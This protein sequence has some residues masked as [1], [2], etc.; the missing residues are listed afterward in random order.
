[1]IP[2]VPTSFSTAS[3]PRS[4]N[5][6]RFPFRQG[7]LQGVWVSSIAALLLGGL[8]LSCG[9]EKRSAG[10]AETRVILLITVDTLRA[11]RLGFLGY[12]RETSP[13]LDAWAR[14][15]VVFERTVAQFPKTGPSLAALFTSRYPQTTGLTH[16]AA[17]RLP[18][19]LP[20][21]PELLRS[22]GF[23]AGAVVS[24]P[25]LPRRL[26]WA[27]GFDD[28]QEVW[29]SDAEAL[30]DPYR[31]RRVTEAQRVNEAA[32]PL[33]R[34]AAERVRGG[35][36]EFLW[37][38]YSDPHAPYQLPPGETN[39]FLGDRWFVGEETALPESWAA[40]DLD[41]R[42]DLRY[43]VAQYDANV[44]YVDRRIGELLDEAKRVGLLAEGLVV[45]T[46]DHGESLGEHGA[47]FDHGG[48]PYATTSRVPLF[49]WAGGRL[50]AARVAAPTQLIDL[51]PTLAGFLGT[52]P[53]PGAEGNDLGPRLR[54]T[55]E[56]GPRYAFSEAGSGSGARRTHF[57]VVEDERFK[58]VF[59]PAGPAGPAPPAGKGAPAVARPPRWEFFDLV[60]DPGERTNLIERRPEELR[61]L[62][63]ALEAWMR[64][65][66]AAATD[67][68]QSA[69]TLRALRALG[70][71]Q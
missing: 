42:R 57:R 16:R 62:R 1:M 71:L 54:G 31:L 13:R 18:E 35:G 33:L 40:R 69:E 58:L 66:V 26:G 56:P 46:A 55:A 28:Y 51:V 45:F 2:G 60:A 10:L 52:A 44:R 21:L 29:Q 6:G 43:Y 22:R 5:Q 25:V 7:N 27:Q 24:N 23:H 30:D 19:E 48:E 32:M 65:G 9:A 36:R 15:G 14:E 68:D 64:Q 61:R 11:D 41:G 47:Y 67:D 37:I 63:A 38:H 39:P 12:P 53:P 59:H 4:T 34:A 50:P 8:G 20:T 17:V 70:Y 49:L 3:S